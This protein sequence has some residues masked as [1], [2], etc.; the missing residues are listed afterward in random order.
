MDRRE[1]ER[2]GERK[3]ENGNFILL[4]LPGKLYR[5]TSPTETLRVN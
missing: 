3:R 1:S 5:R 2:V 4:L